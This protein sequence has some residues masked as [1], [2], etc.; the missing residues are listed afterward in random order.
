MKYLGHVVSSE[1]VRPDPEEVRAIRDYPQPRSVAEVRRFLGLAS[2]HRRFINLFADIASPLHGIT[3]K[4]VVFSWTPECEQAF[5]TLQEHLSLSLILAYPDFTQT[6]IV[7]TDAS[8][9]GLG[10]ILSQGQHIIEYAS[11]GLLYSDDIKT[12]RNWWP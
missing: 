4:E 12:V 5:R 8:D 1:I 3:Q 9:I 7:E 6:F 2:Y 11:R 10:A